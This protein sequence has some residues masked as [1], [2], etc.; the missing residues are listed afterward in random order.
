MNALEGRYRLLFRAYPRAHRQEREDEVV[1]VLLDAARPGQQ[2]PTVREAASIVGNGLLVRAR[3]ADDWREGV[4]WAGLAALA[5]AVGMAG[6]AVGIAGLPPVSSALV[7]P[8]YGPAGPSSA[9]FPGTFWGVGLV[10]ALVVAVLDGRRV[11]SIATAAIAVLA[12]VGTVA[13]SDVAGF[14]RWYVVP[15]VAFLGLS[16]LAGGATR[17]SRLVAVAVGSAMAGKQFLRFIERYGDSGWDGHHVPLWTAMSRWSLSF[18]LTPLRREH[19]WVLI[20]VAC[21]AAL[22]RPAIA[23]AAGLLALP[24]AALASGPLAKAT[25]VGEGIGT[26]GLAVLGLFVLALVIGR[27]R[28]VKLEAYGTGSARST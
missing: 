18:E 7:G 24:L 27:Y 11:R 9:W 19:W 20:G 17:R 25:L 2:R 10:L 16:L 12:G 14:L 26:D 15:F 4:R 13:G 23:V 21:V 3:S 5:L 22:W 8:G 1:G 28:S 6:L